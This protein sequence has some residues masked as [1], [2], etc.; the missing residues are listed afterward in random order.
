MNLAHHNTTIAAA[1]AAAAQPAPLNFNYYDDQIF[2]TFQHDTRYD[3]TDVMGSPN[4][5]MQ[6]C[7]DQDCFAFYHVEMEDHKKDFCM[8]AINNKNGWRFKSDDLIRFGNVPGAVQFSKDAK[9]ARTYLRLFGDDKDEVQD[10]NLDFDYFFDKVIPFVDAD[11]GYDF[12]G[13]EVD[14]LKDCMWSC[15]D[16]DCGA[17]Y[18]VQM[19]GPKQDQCLISYNQGKDSKFS[20]WKEEQLIPFKNTPGLVQFPPESLA[21]TTYIRK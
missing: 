8:M 7:Y 6:A 20:G 14:S 12:T 16:L 18:Y 10:P 11:T 2:L 21:A 19:K 1:S 9:K 3:F 5:C 4:D 17:F 13:Y 15:K